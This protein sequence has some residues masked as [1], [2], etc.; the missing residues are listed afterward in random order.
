MSAWL[1]LTADLS[2]IAGL[3]ASIVAVIYAKSA[4]Q[5]ARQARREV[6]RGNVSEALAEL[7]KT[8]TLLRS[9]VENDQ[10]AEAIVRSRDLIAE[11]SRSRLRWERYLPTAS[12][13][14]LDESRE[15][16]SVIS[17]SLATRGAPET[18]QKKDRLL[19]ICHEVVVV[20][21]EESARILSAIENE[22]E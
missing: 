15:Q 5:A 2:S 17:R 16:I 12:A 1:S 18:P 20:L 14:R 9:T 22:G 6:R 4:E 8:A 19:R 10:I 11:L 3:I 21:G 13:V 7:S